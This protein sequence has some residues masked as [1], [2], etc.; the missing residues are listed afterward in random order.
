MTIVQYNIPETLTE[1][2]QM[3]IFLSLLGNP[4]ATG[5]SLVPIVDN[6]EELMVP[7]L[8]ELGKLYFDF[9]FVIQS[10]SDNQIKT[11]SY[12]FIQGSGNSFTVT[13]FENGKVSGNGTARVKNTSNGE[14]STVTFSF[15]DIA[16]R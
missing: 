7:Y 13:K 12:E 2:P 10:L 1:K 4:Y 3:G 8:P 9:D 14:I 15:S 16:E 11:S 5:A 6:Y